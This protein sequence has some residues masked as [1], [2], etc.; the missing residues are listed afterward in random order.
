MS[1]DLRMLTILDD[2]ILVQLGSAP[3]SMN[4][5]QQEKFREGL[6]NLIG[7]MRIRNVRDFSQLVAEIVAFRQDFLGDKSKVLA[8]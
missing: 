1:A 8:L 4:P 3:A 5:E 7:Q 2:K 6:R